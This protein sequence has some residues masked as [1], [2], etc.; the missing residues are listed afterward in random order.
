VL[1]RVEVFTR[2][3][4]P[5]TFALLN[6]ERIKRADENEII[7]IHDNRGFRNLIIIIIEDN[8]MN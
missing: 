8:V 3:F 2:R 6:T 7:T 1:R 5:L 4:L